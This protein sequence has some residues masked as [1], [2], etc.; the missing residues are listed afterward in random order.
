[1]AI[2]SVTTELAMDMVLTADAIVDR[3]DRRK[4]CQDGT[5]EQMTAMAD[6]LDLA[7]FVLGTTSS[8]SHSDMAARARVLSLAV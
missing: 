1:V 8:M 5:P 2:P 3:I 4:V 7:Y 6:A